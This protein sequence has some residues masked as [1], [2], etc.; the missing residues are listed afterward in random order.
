MAKDNNP[1][2]NKLK[3]SPWL[4]YGVIVFI[5]LAISFATGGS[6]FQDAHNSS[7]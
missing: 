3:I 5:F 1:N 4:V 2:P 7:S 6:S